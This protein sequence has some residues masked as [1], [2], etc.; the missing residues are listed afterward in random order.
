MITSEA[1]TSAIE[2]SLRGESKLKNEATFE[3]GGFTSPAIRHL[4]N[5]L[6]AIAS[7]YFE[8]GTHMGSL[9]LATLY[10]NQ[11]LTSTICD[12]WT[13]F[14]NGGQS[15]EA[16]YK[17]IEHYHQA[18]NITLPTVFEQD[19]FE[20]P[21]WVKKALKVDLYLYDGGHSYEQQY[22]GVKDFVDA[23]KDE[24]ILVVDDFNWEQVHSATEDAIRDA[25]LVKVLW[26]FFN[27]P[28][29]HNGIGLFLLKKQ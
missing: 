26:G 27:G 22:K 4:M 16:F 7:N 14:E 12:N 10:N 8:I 6:G 25:G 13:E 19:C 11:H 15:K 20:I 29:W 5:N 2:A 17:N 23:M 1:I 24:C 9:T 18:G 28:Q 3:V 21:D